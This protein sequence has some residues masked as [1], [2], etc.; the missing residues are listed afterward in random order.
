MAGQGQKGGGQ[1]QPVTMQAQTMPTPPTG[2]NVNQAASR[3][4]QGALGA[5]Q[6]AVAAPLNVGAYMNPYTQNVIDT[7]QADIERQRQ[8]AVNDLGAAATRANAF[9]GSRQGVAEGVTN[10]E[11]GRV[12]GNLIAPMRRDA[13]NRSLDAAMTDRTQRLNAANQLGGL[14]NQAFTTGRTLNQDM[15]QQGIMQRALQQSLIDAARQDFAGYAGSPMQSLTP[16]I[17]ALGAAPVPQS[18][19]TRENPGILGILGGLLPFFQE[20]NMVQQTGLLGN[21][22][23]NMQRGFG[24]IGDA[25]TG[26]DP[27]ARD[28]LAIALMSLSGNPQQTQAL[29]Q[30]AAKRIEDRKAQAQTNKSIAYLKS[31][32]PQLGAMAEQNPSLVNTIMSEIVKSR[33]ATTDPTKMNKSIMDFRKE[34]TGLKSVKDFSDISFSFSRVVNSATDPSAAGDLALIFNFMKVLDPGSV[35]REGEFATASNAGG[36]DDRVRNIYN[37]VIEGTR[38]TEKQRA[39]FVDRARRL[40]S[41]AEDQ[42]MNLAGQYSTFAKNAGLVPEQVIP[43]FRFKGQ[44]PEKPTILQVPPKPSR[45]ATE[46]DWRNAWQNVDGNGFT[47]EMRREYLEA[48]DG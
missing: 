8:M 27:N 18:S 14:A 47:E 44:I 13:Y 46:A 32:N 45:Y 36:V 19:T 4:L 9:G 10:A 43:D 25:I 5:T 29:Q 12:A 15:M 11:F 17:A 33:F 38:L 39:D 22:G 21:F 24:R 28:Q 31:I 41:G 26:K 16:T 7:T 34:F 40:Y 20:L 23:Q 30:L 48:L 37:R 2:F 3:G 6:A 35:V 1:V 42:Y